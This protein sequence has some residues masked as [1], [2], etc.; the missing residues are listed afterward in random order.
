LWSAQNRCSVWAYSPLNSHDPVAATKSRAGRLP[1]AQM[2]SHRPFGSRRE[3]PIGKIM[4]NRR[5]IRPMALISAI[6]RPASNPATASAS[7]PHPRCAEG[8][9]FRVCGHEGES[10]DLRLRGEQPVE[11]IAVKRRHQAGGADVENGDGK[12]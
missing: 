9:H 11:R 5:P 12:N 3:A 8:L 2:I 7:S 6:R 10:F 4:N 1:I